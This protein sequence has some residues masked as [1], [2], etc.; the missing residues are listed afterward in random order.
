[1]HQAL[2]VTA[3]PAP[4]QGPAPM[5]IDQ[6]KGKPKGKD[7]KG[8]AKG[9]KGA[10]GKDKGKQKNPGKGAEKSG[11]GKGAGRATSADRCLY[12]NK[13]GHGKCDCRKLKADQSAGHAQAVADEC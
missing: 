3:P 11:K 1:M 5:E 7:P 9:K 13:L 6:I 4:D 2:G 10:K 8:K 12:C